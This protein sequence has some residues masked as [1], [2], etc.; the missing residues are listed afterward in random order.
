MGLVPCLLQSLCCS[1]ELS[2]LSLLCST[3]FRPPLL[4]RL[5]LFSL[6]HFDIRSP[7]VCFVAG[8]NLLFV[9]FCLL[10]VVGLKKCVCTH[11]CVV[12]SVCMEC[13][14]IVSRSVS[15][16]LDNSRLDPDQRYSLC[17]FS[18]S[19]SKPVQS[20]WVQLEIKNGHEEQKKRCKA[21]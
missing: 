15:C 19:F 10:L 20:E 12:Y 8:E 3:P 6:C 1:C 2:P 17:S 14:Y 21:T 16:G 4:L 5:P 18:C 13:V 7:V 11:E 9:V